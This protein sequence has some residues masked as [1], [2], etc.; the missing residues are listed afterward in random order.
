MLNYLKFGEH[1]ASKIC[2]FVIMQNAHGIYYCFLEADLWWECEEAV[3]VMGVMCD[4]TQ[5][6]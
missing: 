1:K 3:V 5:G 6:T 4:V 2:M